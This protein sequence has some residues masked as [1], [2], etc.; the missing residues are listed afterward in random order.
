LANKHLDSLKDFII[1]Q[2]RMGRFFEGDSDSTQ[3]I[4]GAWVPAADL[5]ETSEMIV[6][7]LEL[8]GV[9]EDDVKIDLWENYITIQGER[10]LKGRQENYLCMERSY[11]PFQ[12][13]FRLP[14]MV[15]E[16]DVKA[17]FQHGVLK[18]SMRK[19]DEPGHSVVRVSI[20]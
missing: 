10:S 7:L 9:E 12:R 14:A 13:T 4:S 16:D 15:E 20:R 1:L 19:R 8:A 17:E 6:V 2:E 11:G 5:Y 3:S 18:I